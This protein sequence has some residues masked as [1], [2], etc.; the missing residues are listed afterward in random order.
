MVGVGRSGVPA[1]D[2]GPDGGEGEE[3]A[4][5]GEDEG[6][7]FGDFFVELEGGEYG[8]GID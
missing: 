5:D 2:A 8:W 4:D 6:A 3:D 1:Y 7:E